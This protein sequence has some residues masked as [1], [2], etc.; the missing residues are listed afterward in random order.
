MINKNDVLDVL[1]IYVSSNEKEL[2][3]IVYELL[4][5]PIRVQGFIEEIN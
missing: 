1:K 3:Q 5:D 4:V 2:E